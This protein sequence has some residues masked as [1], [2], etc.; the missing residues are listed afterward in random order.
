MFRSRLAEC[1]GREIH[2]TDWGNE[3][4][5]AVALWH[6]L[7]RN[8]RDFDEAAAALCKAGKRAICPDA[9]GR[10]LSEWLPPEDYRYEIYAQAAVALLDRLQIRECDWVGTS[11]GG[12]L[13]MR[14]AAG[15]LRGRIRRLVV[16]DIGPVIPPPALAR[17]ASYA[18]NP[19]VFGRVS[20]FAEWLREAYRPFGENPDS[21][22]ERL[23]R[24]S[25]RRLPDGKIT[26]HYDPRIVLPFT[27]SAAGANGP[28][29]SDGSGGLDM[30][31][32]YDSI[33]CP[34]LL[35]RGAESDVLP[36]AVAEE[37]TRRGPCARLEVFPNCGH[38]PALATA[39]QIAAVVDF[40]AG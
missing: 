23:V 6:G 22:W 1:G 14:L 15:A 3:S 26:A 5:P 11:M 38:A 37:M 20:E 12:L 27:R 13:G 24:T 7:T 19:P 4:D 2:F 21:F 39:R 31:A 25:H 10:G 40:L 35:L 30:W 34:V 29:G 18:G 17:I 16:N 28:G 36:Q 32:E 33:G 8:G 9:P